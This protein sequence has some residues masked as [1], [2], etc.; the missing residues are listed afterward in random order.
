MTQAVTR[1]EL[2]RKAGLFNIAEVA[3]IIGIKRRLFRYELERGRVA[4]P[5][6]RIGTRNRRFYT[7]EDL[8]A[9]KAVLKEE[10]H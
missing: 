9:I 4:F 5:S 1:D 10:Q 7:A 3:D 8:E 6:V 2:R